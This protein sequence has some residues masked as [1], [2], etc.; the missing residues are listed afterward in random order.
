MN[1]CVSIHPIRLNSYKKFGTNTGLFFTIQLFCFPFF[2]ADI[3]G[4]D[5]LCYDLG[6]RKGKQRGLAYKLMRRSNLID[7]SLVYIQAHAPQT[8]SKVEPRL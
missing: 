7:G 3:D 8:R 4:D 5:P 2:S 6:S 1:K